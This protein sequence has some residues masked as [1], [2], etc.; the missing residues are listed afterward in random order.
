MYLTGSWLIV[1]FGVDDDVV[2][3]KRKRK[4][5]REREEAILFYE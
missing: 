1:S 3:E 2:N 4:R 5:K